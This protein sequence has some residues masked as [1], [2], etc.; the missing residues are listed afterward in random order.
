MNLSA[1]SPF[2]NFFHSPAVFSGLAGLPT[3]PGEL[4]GA[5]HIAPGP[6]HYT[7]PTLRALPSTP[8]LLAVLSCV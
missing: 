7:Q 2:V 1:V 3:L 4:G 6:S 8:Q 5:G